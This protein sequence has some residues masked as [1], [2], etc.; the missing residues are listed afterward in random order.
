MSGSAG[1]GASTACAASDRCGESRPAAHRLRRLKSSEMIQSMGC[2]TRQP[3]CLNCPK[4]ALNALTP[5]TNCGGEGTK[6]CTFYSHYAY[7]SSLHRTK[8]CQK[9]GGIFF[10]R[11]PSTF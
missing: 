8:A 5:A 10:R 1:N 2:P 6:S 3:T 9:I 4:E 11:R 7:G